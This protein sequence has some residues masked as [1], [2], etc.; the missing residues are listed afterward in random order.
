MFKI[1]DGKIYHLRGDTAEFDVNITD[2]GTPL[3]NYEAV[4]TVKRMLKDSKF[5]FQKPVI[6]GHVRN[7]PFGNYYYDIAVRIN[8]GTE[9]GRYVSLPPNRYFL[10]AD[11]TTEWGESDEP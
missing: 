3:E 8:D 5:L 1:K 10:M 6:N 4:F 11:V 7:L 9:E 2:D